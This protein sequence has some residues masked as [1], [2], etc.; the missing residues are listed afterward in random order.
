MSVGRVNVRGLRALRQALR[1]TSGKDFDRYLAKAH[2]LIAQEVVEK[3]RP[4]IAAKSP[5]TAAA[6]RAMSSATGAR[7]AVSRAD[8]PMAAG[9]IFGA[10][11]NI[12]RQ[13]RRGT[14]HGYNQFRPWHAG[15]YHL[16]PEADAMAAEMGQ[17]YLDT[18]QQFL[19][20]QGVP[21]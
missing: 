5:Q 8:A 14:Y 17:A 18:I 3:A 2:K 9:I 7:I 13:N 6:T 11:Q 1:A 12:L 10:V 21:R 4:G 19:D 20:A 15:P 16:F